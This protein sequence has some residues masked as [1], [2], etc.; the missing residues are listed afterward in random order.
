ME[1]IIGQAP[2]GAGVI[3]DGNAQSFQADVIEA[4]KT[5]PVIVDFW[6]PWCGPCKQLGPAIERAVREANGAVRLV[7]INI[8]ENQPI[9]RAMRIQSIPAVYAFKQ[10]QPVDGFVGAL[11]ESQVKAFVKRLVG[12]QGPS[13][14]E[15]ALAQAKEAAAAGDHGTAGA[16]FQQILRHEPTNGEAFGGLLRALMGRDQVQAARDLLAKAS[17]ELAKHPAVAGVTTA[18][19]L[20]DEAGKAGDVTQLAAR[21][22]SNPDDHQARLDLAV[23]LFARGERA[24]ALDALIQIIRRDREWNEQA[25]RGQMLKFFEAMGPTDPLTVEGR[26]KLSAAWFA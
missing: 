21:V 11:P 16:L 3:K 25:A 13:P 9:A 20:L 8:D 7:K 4:S 18:L 15:E 19:A 22:E 12:D 10:G 26:R 24:A 23:A 14:V 6:A 17:P 5:L 1:P 2:G